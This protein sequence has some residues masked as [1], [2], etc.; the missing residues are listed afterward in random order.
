MVKN[1]INLKKTASIKHGITMILSAAATLIGIDPLT[2]AL[3]IQMIFDGLYQIYL[4]YGPV[5][6]RDV[7]TVNLHQNRKLWYLCLHFECGSYSERENTA[8]E[9]LA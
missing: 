4:A 1:S 8:H 5:K 2:T 9:N 3:A 7:L 6:N